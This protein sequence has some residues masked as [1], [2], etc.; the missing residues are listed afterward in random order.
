MS[1]SYLSS[2]QKSSPRTKEIAIR[3]SESSDTL[4]PDIDT[5]S[6]NEG[7]L[8]ID[9]S[10]V[11]QNGCE[12]SP[13]KEKS[14]CEHEKPSSLGGS[15]SSS[16]VS[17]SDTDPPSSP[18]CEI[19]SI[20]TVDSIPSSS[21]RHKAE[22]SSGAEHC[23]TPESTASSTC[24]VSAVLASIRSQHRSIMPAS[25][26]AKKLAMTAIGSGFVKKLI[27]EDGM[28]QDLFRRF[29]KAVVSVT[30]RLKWKHKH[31]P[32]TAIFV[33]YYNKVFRGFV[34]ATLSKRDN[35]PTDLYKREL[36][37][38]RE[39]CGSCVSKWKEQLQRYILRAGT[40][41]KDKKDLEAFVKNQTTL[42]QNVEAT[43]V[44]KASNTCTPDSGGDRPHKAKPNPPTPPTTV[45]Q[46]GHRSSELDMPTD[47]RKAKPHPP[48]PHTPTAAVE[49]KSHP[50][51]DLDRLT[52]PRMAMPLP[53]S[54]ST[55]SAQALRPSSAFTPVISA[56]S[57]PPSNRT[58]SSKSTDSIT[59]FTTSP[60][61]PVKLL[62]GQSIHEDQL[63]TESPYMFK[64]LRSSGSESD[65]R[66]DGS[67][68]TVDCS[69]D[70]SL[71]PELDRAPS[72]FSSYSSSP[73][74]SS[75]AM[76][77]IDLV[78]ENLPN[79]LY[80][81]LPQ[82]TGSSL[83]DEEEALTGEKLAMN[84]ILSSSKEGIE[85]TPTTTA[86]QP[87]PSKMTVA[88]EKA[89]SDTMG[90]AS[91]GVKDEFGSKKS[92]SKVDTISEC[93]VSSVD[94]TTTTSESYDSST[95]A[96]D[97]EIISSSSSPAP[98]PPPEKE[99][100]LPMAY[101]DPERW[102]LVN[103]RERELSWQR[104]RHLSHR[105][106]RSRSSSPGA[107]RR[108]SSPERFYRRRQS[109]YRSRSR[110]WSRDRMLRSRD[111]RRRSMS[112]DRPS[113][114][115]DRR[116]SRDR[117]YHRS[118]TRSRSRGKS[119]SPVRR[120]RNQKS[121]AAEK[122]QRRASR[123]D[124]EK[125]RKGSIDSE[126]EL[127]ILK[128]EA[129]ASMKQTTSE[130][131]VKSDTR[132]DDSRDGVENDERGEADM[133]LCSQSSG[134]EG[135]GIGEGEADM[136]LCSESSREGDVEKRV[137]A[138]RGRRETGKME[139]GDES[140]QGNVVGNS[141]IDGDSR[142]WVTS[143]DLVNASTI[144]SEA[145]W[146][147]QQTD[148]LELSRE[149]L[150]A[151]YDII[152][153][154]SSEAGTLTSQAG[155]EGTEDYGSTGQRVKPAAMCIPAQASL[156]VG[157]SASAPSATLG[158]DTPS[159]LTVDSPSHTMDD[160]SPTPHIVGTIVTGQQ[161]VSRSESSNQASI[162][163]ASSQSPADK[164]S[165]PS[166]TLV[167]QTSATKSNLPSS[168]TEKPPAAVASRSKSSGITAKT[169]QPST[170][171]ITETS[172]SKAPT[173]KTIPPPTATKESAASVAATGQQ[174]VAVTKARRPPLAKTTQVKS[175]QAPSVK[176]DQASNQTP[177]VK[178]TQVKATG[179]V[180]LVKASKASS[181]KSSQSA[182]DKA[183]QPSSGQKACQV[184]VGKSSQAPGL[185]TTPTSSSVV[186]KSSQHSVPTAGSKVAESAAIK[187]L[188][189]S[190]SRSSSR[191][192]SKA[193]SPCLS[194][195]HAS[196]PSG[197]NDSLGVGGAV[198]GSLSSDVRVRQRSGSCVKVFTRYIYVVSGC[199]KYSA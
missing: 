52:D 100:V 19:L 48:A 186:A 109:R 36:K 197:S 182:Q 146:N 167:S 128:R 59:K 57:S 199:I 31:K 81:C 5:D 187:S 35:T 191:S 134:E 28:E 46:K 174:S 137:S 15:L 123:G 8:V 107:K 130:S 165:E 50:T 143:G 70:Y 37:A 38:L 22:S 82:R 89:L 190:I 45:Q 198:G 51:S 23:A 67:A 80:V 111:R 135:G 116:R 108:G 4:R 83:A 150:V 177:S 55:S 115:H 41:P 60:K 117:R 30:E 140:S 69:A 43:N 94:F 34:T 120:L 92:S 113:R 14:S 10:F 47:P 118:R 149:V 74:P 1:D 185:K 53:L 98:S 11:S 155:T 124:H 96:E 104:Y 91:C 64:P 170:V 144:Q 133:D 169:G 195:T 29:F 16:V 9:E 90:S 173:G 162:L 112:R 127:E 13:E 99:T 6:D 18:D 54:L 110:S 66:D 142:V 179:Q 148:R 7:G 102:R 171:G 119:R 189:K 79:P 178:S 147:H 33:S 172:P 158:K 61:R 32:T 156:S 42:Q 114:S 49:L 194:P 93:T 56:S 151:D 154:R 125:D 76:V 175:S 196:S 131:A 73:V 101:R 63:D 176:T 122:P 106:S 152:A 136:E 139:K 3:S 103:S 181:V 75:D 168:D 183:G 72:G 12:A 87:G 2:G 193:N 62:H 27:E 39:K 84:V 164:T 121:T 105:S 159:P 20:S 86:D 85:A 132:E 26:R 97:G 21:R 77:V 163:A 192:G 180:Q 161:P 126:D 153:G 138:D 145:G 129:L 188:K 68:F 184:A 160:K 95:E 141:T 88:S 58:L 24:S 44:A 78:G 17:L 65:Q 166:A 71:D 25:Q 40:L 157:R